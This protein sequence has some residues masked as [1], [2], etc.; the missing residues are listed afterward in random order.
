MNISVINDTF[1]KAE[2]KFS[3]AALALSRLTA[4][5][6][7]QSQVEQP[8]TAVTPEQPVVV[9]TPAQP[10]MIANPAHSI[11]LVRKP[12]PVPA[13][14]QSVAS[15]VQ[16]P[17]GPAMKDPLGELMKLRETSLRQTASHSDAL[18]VVCYSGHFESTVVFIRAHLPN[19]ASV[20]QTTPDGQVLEMKDFTCET[21]S[22]I[23]R[24]LGHP[25]GVSPLKFFG[26]E[27]SRRPEPGEDFARWEKLPAEL[28]VAN[29]LQEVVHFA[30]KYDVGFL[31][32]HL[33][34]MIA[35]EM[36]SESLFRLNDQYN[37]GLD[38][39]LLANTLVHF[40]VCHRAACGM[41]A[42]AIKVV[43]FSD[44]KTYL[45]FR[46]FLEDY[47]PSIGMVAFE[48][49]RNGFLI[50]LIESGTL[51]AGIDSHLVPLLQKFPPGNAIKLAALLPIDHQVAYQDMI[52]PVDKI[53]SDAVK[54]KY[55]PPEGS[56]TGGSTSRD[57]GPS[58]VPQKKR[59]D[60]S[61]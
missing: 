32:S 10:T 45:L 4:E 53:I 35:N 61:K 3:K 54:R 55:V 33:R 48:Q 50:S 49:M 28:A 56:K 17:P 57:K 7:A 1:A 9:A 2:D 58:E 19:L 20:I 16:Q 52:L 21:V 15:P 59:K 14:E 31:L 27:R 23:F 60:N 12:A 38:S 5:K 39:V 37:L 29:K 41:E 46:P 51:A 22:M 47:S 25:N 18:R 6:S 26:L 36:P 13:P 43:S 34:L 8:A 24:F 42:P 11:R 40:Q 30:T 44:Q